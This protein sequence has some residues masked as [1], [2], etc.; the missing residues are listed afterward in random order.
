MK[1]KKG[2]FTKFPVRLL[3]A[4]RPPASGSFGLVDDP[5]K[6][7]SFALFLHHLCVPS[8]GNCVTD[9]IANFLRELL[10]SIWFFPIRP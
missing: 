1:N 3:L 10:N 9:S 6:T 8:L 5:Q 7:Y 2:L 4:C